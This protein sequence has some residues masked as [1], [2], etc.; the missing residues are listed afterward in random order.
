M[1]KKGKCYNSMLSEAISKMG[2][3]D[4]ILI[5]DAGC[6][7]PRHGQTKVIDLALCD[8]IPSVTDVLKVIMSELVVEGYMIPEE[9]KAQSPLQYQKYREILDREENKEW[10]EHV[11]DKIGDFIE[12]EYDNDI[13]KFYNDY[14]VTD[15]R[16]KGQG[17]S[18]DNFEKFINQNYLLFEPYHLYYNENQKRA[19]FNYLS[20]DKQYVQVFDK[21]NNNLDLPRGT[22]VNIKNKIEK[23]LFH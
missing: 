6:A 20:N 10:L 15:F 17:L 22:L 8:G 5:G 2:H 18:F 12:E 7:W 14:N 13:N 21:D 1:M 3:G 19:L 4:I 23:F 9:M 16:N 11:V